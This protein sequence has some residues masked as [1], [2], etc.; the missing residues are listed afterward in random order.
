MSPLEKVD[1]VLATAEPVLDPE[2]E[3]SQRLF[4]RRD[5]VDMSVYDESLGGGPE[6]SLGA[7]FLVSRDYV[8]EVTGAT[9]NAASAFVFF[10]D[11]CRDMGPGDDP[12]DTFV[13]GY[14]LA[15][16]TEL[17]G[18]LTD[19]DL[20][21]EKSNAT[22]GIDGQAEVQG[23]FFDYQLLTAGAYFKTDFRGEAA[24]VGAEAT[25]QLLDLDLHLGITRRGD[26]WLEW[27]LTPIL[28]ADVLTVREGGRTGLSDDTDYA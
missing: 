17:D 4:L 18:T 19:D 26:P 2:C 9:I 5:K 12:R 27:Y 11:A 20:P 23:G 13:P 6:E 14:S 7:R 24:A 22:V 3:L 8:G 16:Y 10:R 28:R 1:E 15:G 25:W 21:D